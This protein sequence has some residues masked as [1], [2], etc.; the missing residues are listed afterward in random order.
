MFLI[1]SLLFGFSASI[2]SFIVGM[3]YG[4]KKMH[5]SSCK[6]L[7]IST[8]TLVGTVLSILAGSRIAPFLPERAAKAAGSMILI[9]LGIYY[10]V[11]FI[12]I[13]FK[14]RRT[15]NALSAN[16]LSANALSYSAASGR[17]DTGLLTGREA[18]ALG[19]ALSVNNIGIGLGASISGIR[20][21]ST[22]AVTFFL[23]ILLL[24]LGNRLGKLHFLQFA[25]RFADPLAGLILIVLGLYEWFA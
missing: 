11:K 22:A 1:S 21:A 4:V 12:L 25:G 15:A 17:P 20:L 10:I 13:Y 8:I 9:L 14:K 2:D 3:T 7:I 24:A 16:A 19:L 23:S 5:I 18:A 6:N